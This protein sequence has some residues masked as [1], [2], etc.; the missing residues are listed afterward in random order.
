MA[1]WISPE[2]L[3]EPVLTAGEGHSLKLGKAQALVR[4]AVRAAR[5]ASRSSSL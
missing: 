2:S 3:K 4:V 5:S 1:D